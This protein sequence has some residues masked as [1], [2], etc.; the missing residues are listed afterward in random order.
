M[1]KTQTFTQG[2]SK[3]GSFSQASNFTLYVVLTDR[4]GNAGTNVSKVDYNVYCQSNGSGSITAKH[5]KYFSINGSEKINTTESVNVSSPYAYIPIASGTIEVTHNTDGSKS[6]PFSAEIRGASFGVS[7]SISGTF[8]LEKIPR[9]FS[10]TPSISLSKRTLTSI[11]FKWSTSETCDKINYT[12]NG[13][14]KGEIWAGSS[15]NGTLTINNL[16]PNTQYSLYISCRRKDSQLS[17]NSNTLSVST[18]DIARITEAPNV[19][20]GNSHTIKWTNPGGATLSLKLCKTDGTQVI[21]Y[22][23]VTGTSKTVTPTASTIYA[24]TPNSNTIILR[25]ILTTTQGSYTTTNY[26]DCKFSVTN[27]NPTFSNFTYQD[28]NSTTLALTGNNQ[29]II[30]GYSNVK[31]IISVANKASAKNSATMSKYRFS[32]GEKTAETAYS[33]TAQ[34]EITINGVQSNSFTMYAIDSRGNS[35]GKTLTAASYINYS[36]IKIT[37]ISLIRTNSVNSET[38]LKFSGN[39]WNGSFG[40]V[41]NS[42]VS[43]SYKYKLSTTSSWTTGKTT[44]TPTKN[45]GSFSFSGI[46]KG[47]LGANGFNIDNSYNIQ[48]LISDKLSNNNSNPAT[49]TLGPGTPG[50]AIYKN[51]VAIGQRYDT[52]DGS[53]LQVNGQSKFKGNV[54]LKH[55]PANFGGCRRITVA[56]SYVRLFTHTMSSQWKTAGIWFTLMDTQSN[57]EIMLCILYIHKGETNTAISNF[58][59]I[60]SD[61]ETDTS[62]LSA[63]VTDNNTV[64]V[65]FKMTE[66]DSPA[67][68][69]LSHTKLYEDDDAY[70]KITIDCNT[71]KTSLP[72]GVHPYAWIR[73]ANAPVRL[74]NRDGRIANANINHIYH[75]SRAHLQLL[76]ATGSMTANKPASD[77]YILHFS[78]DNAGAYNAQ[79][80]IGNSVGMGGTLQ[81]RGCNG[82]NGTWGSWETILRNKILYDNSSGTTGTITLSESAANFNYLEIFYLRENNDY[83]STRINSPN[84]KLTFLQDTYITSQ[85]SLMQIAVKRIK[86]SGTSI[87][88]V[89]DY[90][91]NLE[92]NKV[93]I[94]AQNVIKIIKVIGYR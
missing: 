35:T 75:N 46:I 29:T 13:T 48:V 81:A 84:N 2:C 10:S 25:Y 67:I 83:A 17:S 80:F 64:E 59:I 49:F 8:Q 53:K 92:T 34:K 36:S 77:G 4:D 23:T 33:S 55:G 52:S 16:K 15:T 61:G 68:T 40:S 87:T 47:D 74:E 54:L 30:K 28:T 45:G 22:G 89:Y 91:A 57:N 41:T 66:N 73:G 94:G 72:S 7:A 71:T 90:Y 3:V 20:I 26:K 85:G 65:Y 43:C 93:S 60:S 86:I 79:F 62:R 37:S 70:G 42:I 63:V 51:N 14:S 38:N 12:L 44:I 76:Q 24:L 11:T 5:Y 21:N 19:N 58:N 39:I 82:A 32:I 27:S 18:Y 78:W 9:Y 50:L 69:I 6:I 56:N 1:A 31:G 88:S